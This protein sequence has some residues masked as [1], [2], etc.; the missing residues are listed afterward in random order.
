M[1]HSL[2]HHLQLHIHT[3]VSPTWAPKCAHTELRLNRTSDD[4]LIPNKPICLLVRNLTLGDLAPKKWTD[5]ILRPWYKIL[6]CW[7][8][9]VRTS[10]KLKVIAAVCKLMSKG[11]KLFCRGRK[12]E[13]T[14]SG[15]ERRAGGPREEDRGRRQLL[16][17]CSSP[18]MLSCTDFM[19]LDSVKSLYTCNKHAPLF[20]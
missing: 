1:F 8:L 19:S 18:L 20:E 10:H 3:L 7:Q 14:I 2:A 12:M 6:D 13:L 17:F 15:E 16:L 4:Q 5:S 9:V 11:R